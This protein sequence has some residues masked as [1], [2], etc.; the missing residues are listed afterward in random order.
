M[1]YH[2]HNRPILKVVVALESSKSVYTE[3]GRSGYTIFNSSVRCASK[4]VEHCADIYPANVNVGLDISHFFES[5]LPM[6]R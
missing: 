6:R 4:P 3:D 2:S 1:G 5:R